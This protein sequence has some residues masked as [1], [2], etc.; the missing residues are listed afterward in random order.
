MQAIGWSLLLAL[1]GGAALAADPTTAPEFTHQRP[2][3]WLN[4]DPLTLA[5]LKGKVVL[6]EFWA[7]ECANCLNSRAWIESVEKTKG[8]SGLVIIGVHTPELP[9]E[10]DGFKL[11]AAVKRLQ[12]DYPVMIDVDRS[13]WNALHNKVWPEFYLI[14]RDGKLYGS[15]I[16]EM[17]VGE[18]RAEVAEQAI[19]KLLAAPA[20]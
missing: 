2:S 18:P 6:V 19:D 15:I 13:Y 7:F 8:P 5:K 1:L 9:D 17:H 11:R 20:T 14:G 3:E 10:R 16:G 12:I 4:S